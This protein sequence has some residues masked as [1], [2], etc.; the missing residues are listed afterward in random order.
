[1]VGLKVV[2]ASTAIADVSVEIE[3]GLPVFAAQGIPLPPRKI[4]TIEPEGVGVASSVLGR[5]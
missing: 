2:G 3:Q 5:A 1:V 4:K